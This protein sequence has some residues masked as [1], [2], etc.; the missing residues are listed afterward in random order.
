[1]TLLA[2]LRHGRTEWNAA[3]RLQGR[4]DVALSPEG[5]L[6]LTG[7][8]L[9]AGLA[10]ARWHVS[11]LRRARE[12]AALLGGDDSAVEP[13]LI[14][15]D[16]GEFEG[17]RL[18]ELRAELGAEMARNEARGLDFLPPGGESPRMLQ[19]R[20]QPWLSAIATEGGRHVAVSHKAVIRAVLSLA[21]DWPMQD[22]PPVKLDWTCLHLF[23]LDADGQPRPQQ[24][25]LPLERA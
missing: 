12:T 22:K 18:A 13:A 10:D 4:A 23:T 8:R 1:M 11:P 20:L 2:L 21:Y 6:A 3:G 24:M 19:A 17:R 9:P 14:E 25:N 7:R 15:M 16:F 5:R